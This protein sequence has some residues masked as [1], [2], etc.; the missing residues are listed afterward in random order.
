[1]NPSGPSEQS[2]QRRSRSRSAQAACEPV[3]AAV[4]RALRGSEARRG[5]LVVAV[6]GGVDSTVLAHA[7]CSLAPS[8]GRDAADSGDAEAAR[9]T[10]FRVWLG[11]INHGLRGEDSEADEVFVSNLAASLGCGIAVEGVAPNAERRGR[12]SRERPTLQEAARRVRYDALERIRQRTGAFCVATAHNADDQAETVLLRLMR[13]CGP[14]GLGGI[15][16]VSPSDSVVRP[17]L[18]VTRAEIVAYAQA[19]ELSWREDASNRDVG[20]TRNRLRRDWL[21][22][23]ARDFNPQLLRTIANLAEAQR[24]DAEWISAV[25]AVEAQQRFRREEGSFWIDSDRW[26]RPH[27]ALARRLIQLALG[28][29]GVGR[30]VTR[31]HLARVLSF[32]EVAGGTIAGRERRILELPGGVRLQ[33]AGRSFRLYRVNAKAHARV[34]QN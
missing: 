10:G 22:G 16:E 28:E 9:S 24:R 11:H 5:G 21:P 15:P 18:S 30:E 14:I 27:E 7:V 2:P 13:G 20:Y 12:S 34:A 23:L 33:R 25:V 17:L 32:L 29:L 8:W 4:R 6:S 19:C 26:G 31:V 3:L 1:M